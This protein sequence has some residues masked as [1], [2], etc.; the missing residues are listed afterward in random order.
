VIWPETATPGLL[1]YDAASRA[2]AESVVAGGAW[3][4]A[5]TMDA[6]PETQAFYNAVLLM[7]PA[8][9]IEASY[10][11]RHLVPFGEYVPLTRWIPALERL[12]PLGFSCAV[13]SH[14]Q[15]LLFVP[16]PDGVVPVSTLICFEDVFPYLARRDVRRGARLL[17]NVTNDGWFDGTAAA[18]QHLAMAALRAVENQVPMVRA[19]NSGVSAFIDQAG[20]I[21]E[22]PGPR[23]EGVQGSSVRLVMIP[24]E[25]EYITT[26]TRY[27][28][29]LLAIPCAIATLLL[30]LIGFVGA[31]MNTRV[32]DSKKAEGQTP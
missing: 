22:V 7:N 10:F 27:G 8:R 23:A 2:L 4:L 26:Y 9:R 21:T 15:E 19:A 6:A 20:R 11:K 1:R 18:R 32:Q 28:D 29:W 5:G 17:V 30:T 25:R 24:A 31:R 13:G 12:A 14:D 16:S 3:L